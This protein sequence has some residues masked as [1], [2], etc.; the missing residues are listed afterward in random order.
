MIHDDG[1]Q[2]PSS[3][4][5]GAADGVGLSA[6]WS[7]RFF[8]EP[9]HVRH[10]PAVSAIEDD[11]F[12][13]SWPASAY[14]REIERNYMAYYVV[15][16][17][18]PLGGGPRREP[19]FPVVA[20]GGRPEPDGL[21]ERLGR[22]VRGEAKAYPPEV[23]NELEQVVGY[24]GMWLM[25]DEAHITTVAV[26]PPYRGEGVGE[27]LLVALLDRAF[28]VGAE[29]ATL[30]CRVSNLIAQRLYRKYTFRDMGVRKRYYSDDGEDALIMTTEHLESTGFRYAFDE[31]RRKLLE[32]LRAGAS[33]Q[34][35][36][37]RDEGVPQAPSPNA[38]PRPPSPNPQ[39]LGGPLG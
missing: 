15:A 2:S 36:G 29:T 21:L 37:I 35:T 32:R 5:D 27:L 10:I 31:N 6:S 11:S 17:R 28:E 16:K 1:A 20:T 24:S 8:I 23:A 30:E 9:M 33:G 12:P 14:R 38:R 18:S 39:P 34:G 19:R 26:D 4:R 25:V 13:V 7:L 22:I 3:A